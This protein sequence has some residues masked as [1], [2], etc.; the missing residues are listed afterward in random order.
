M[1][2]LLR[3][4]FK[5][6]I[7]EGNAEKGWL[8]TLRVG[9]SNSSPPKILLTELKANGKMVSPRLGTVVRAAGPTLEIKIARVARRTCIVSNTSRSA[10]H[11]GHIERRD[12]N[13]NKLTCSPLLPVLCTSHGAKN[14]PCTRSGIHDNSLGNCAFAP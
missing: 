7:K 9:I 2:Q 14:A 8:P 4:D 1:I 12:D 13:E 3:W 6:S 11:A 10:A 5:S